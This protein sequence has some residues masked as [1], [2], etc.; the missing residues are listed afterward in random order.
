MSLNMR[1]HLVGDF[2]S[3]PAI[4]LLKI[5]T[6]KVDFELVR[7]LQSS[8]TFLGNVQQATG[9]DIEFLQIGAERI[10]DVRVVHRNDGKG[11]AVSEAGTLADILQFDGHYWK[12]VS[13]D[14]RPWR[15]YCRALVSVLDKA[16]AE[17]LPSA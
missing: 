12:C 13:V 5:V 7:S 3:H 9:R 14:Y 2:V 4:R 10:N 17:K 1:G 6:T 15:N 11:I 8:E 16:E